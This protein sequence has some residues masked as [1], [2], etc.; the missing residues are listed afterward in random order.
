MKTNY[1]IIE[2]YNHTIPKDK[3][4]LLINQKLY[5]IILLAEDSNNA[6]G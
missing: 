5:K 4:K 3:L 1:N 2:V 6:N